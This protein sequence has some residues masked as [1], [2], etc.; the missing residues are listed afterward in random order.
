MDSHLARMCSSTFAR[1]DTNCPSI[2]NTTQQNMRKTQSEIK[3]RKTNNNPEFGNEI[4][5][6]IISVPRLLSSALFAILFLCEN[7]V[8][9]EELEKD[10]ERERNS[11]QI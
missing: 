10:S 4:R 6:N 9:R 7:S 2:H 11:I 8:T 5:I 3:K 1:S